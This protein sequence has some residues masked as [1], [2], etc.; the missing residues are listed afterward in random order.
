MVAAENLCGKGE[1]SA[2]SIY[3]AKVRRSMARNG[4]LARKK[5]K[6]KNVE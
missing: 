2:L 6:E 5:G 3:I 4:L 1:E